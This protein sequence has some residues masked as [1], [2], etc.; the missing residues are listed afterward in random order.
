MPDPPWKAGE[1]S[2]A[3]VLRAVFPK[4][5]RNP[6]S[7]AA[8]TGTGADVKNTGGVFIE[9]KKHSRI[10]GFAVWKKARASARKEKK[11]FTIVVFQRTRSGE[12]MALVDLNEWVRR[13]TQSNAEAERASIVRFLRTA[14][15]EQ[16]IADEIEEGKHHTFVP[17]APSPKRRRRR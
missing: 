8:D 5:V 11:P 6:L 14:F 1:R 7:G 4:A 16:V 17:A 3:D 10:P 15:D 9:Y 13:A 12:R 2:L